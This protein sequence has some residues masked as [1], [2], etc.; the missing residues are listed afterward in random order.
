MY[1]DELKTL[2]ATIEQTSDTQVETKSVN[3]QTIDART[4][5]ADVG[6]AVTDLL[7]MIEV[8][9]KENKELDYTALINEVNELLKPYQT[10]IKSRSTRSKNALLAAEKSI[11]D[12]TAT[13]STPTAQTESVAV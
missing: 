9:K 12:P 6:E 7:N 10:D 8:A 1:V 11:T 13:N 3:K 2:Q 5:K 4:V